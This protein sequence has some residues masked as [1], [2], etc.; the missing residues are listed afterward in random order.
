[1]SIRGLA[2]GITGIAGAVACAIAVFAVPPP[3]GAHPFGDPQTVAIDLEPGRPEVVRVRW[4]VGGLDDLTV[5]GAALGLLPGDR[6]M[7]DGAVS[8]R[9]SDAAAIGPSP[10]F[11]DY[12]LERVTVASDGRE[13]PGAVTPP[14]DLA[15]G[16]A[17]I[18]FTC[19]AAVGVVT[20]GV[21]TLTDLDPAYRTLATGPGGVRAVYTSDAYTHEWTLGGV[22]AVAG[23]GD[24]RGR[25]AALQIAAVVGGLLLIGAVALVLRKRAYA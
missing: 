21:R 11:A 23:G 13:C 2:S 7:L 3:A 22:P 9:D 19:A 10:R 16:G 24:G 6:V 5:L 8:Y 15:R 1:M 20:I 17:T 18:D 25:G 4:K 12:L 14:S